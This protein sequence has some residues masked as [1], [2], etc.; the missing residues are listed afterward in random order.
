[1]RRGRPVRRRNV[2]SGHPSSEL[3]VGVEAGQVSPCGWLDDVRMSR[4]SAHRQGQ[5][6][7]DQGGSRPMDAHESKEHPMTTN[8]T[9]IDRHS[10]LIIGVLTFVILF[11]AVSCT[12]HDVIPVCHYLFGCDHAMH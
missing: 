2:R 10:R 4:R 9:V 12:F 6:G 1:M 11:F 7:W 8:P 3:P 5:P